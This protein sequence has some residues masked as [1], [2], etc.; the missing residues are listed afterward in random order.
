MDFG[1]LLPEIVTSSGITEAQAGFVLTCVFFTYG[2][3]Q[4]VSGYLG[5]KFNPV[6]M[7]SA[8][9]LMIIACNLLIPVSHTAFAMGIIWSVNGFAQ[10]M[11]WP[12]LVRLMSLILSPTAFKKCSADMTVAGVLGMIFLYAV[13]PAVISAGGW[14][15]VFLMAAFLGTIAIAVWIF[16][17]RKNVLES[18]GQRKFR[19]SELFV[20]LKER[21]LFRFLP[22]FLLS[23]VLLGALRDGISTWLPLIVSKRQNLTPRISI[24]L[25]VILPVMGAI[26]SKIASAL[27]SGKNTMKCVF[28]LFFIAFLVSLPMAWG[29]VS[30]LAAFLIPAAILVGLMYGAGLLYTCM[31]PAELADGRCVALSSGV[32]NAVIHIGSATA[33]YGFARIAQDRAWGIMFLLWI[34]F[35]AVG[36]VCCFWI[37]KEQAAGNVG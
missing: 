4:I 24:L 14:K 34:I 30:S 21:R 25:T 32:I 31:I 13:S 26:G 10:S 18:A 37:Y 27:H 20:L 12:P 22:V 1:V 7:V 9:Y 19:I 16:T 6:K 11:L 33:V 5:E 29:I 28:L 23:T 17:L 35:S 2:L 8:G 3:G 15:P 36:T